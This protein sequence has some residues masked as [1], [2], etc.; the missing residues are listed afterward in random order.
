MDRLTAIA[1]FEEVVPEG[2]ECPRCHEAR[3]DWLYIYPRNEADD[4][5]ECGACGNT[6]DILEAPCSQ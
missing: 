5:I 6:Y 4:V 3:T 1:T 2:C